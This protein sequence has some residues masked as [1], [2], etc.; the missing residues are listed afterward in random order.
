[1][2][3]RSRSF[4]L[5]WDASDVV[6]LSS[7]GLK[8]L[9]WLKPNNMWSL[10]RWGYESFHMTKMA[11]MPT[12]MAKNLLKSSFQDWKAN[13]LETWYA[14]LGTLALPSLFKWWPL[15]VFGFCYNKVI[16][17]LLVFCMAKWQNNGYLAHQ[18][19]NVPGEVH[20]LSLLLSSS[21]TWALWHSGPWAPCWKVSNMMEATLY[22]ASFLP[23]QNGSKIC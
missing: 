3:Q 8:L 21:S 22:Y 16:L 10:C 7:S 12:Y 13:E 4:T 11:A 14:A 2:N 19:W 15:V 23:L 9:G 18:S 6:F 20:C 17:G 1:M 5:S